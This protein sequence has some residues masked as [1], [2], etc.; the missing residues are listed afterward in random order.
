MKTF[1]DPV[2]PVYPETRMHLVPR[3]E[4]K[5]FVRAFAGKKRRITGRMPDYAYRELQLGL[6]REQQTLRSLSLLS[7]ILKPKRS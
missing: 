5:L 6:V 4:E 2:K 7:H 1:A 3:E